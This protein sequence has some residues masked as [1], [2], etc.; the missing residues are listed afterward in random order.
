MEK[1]TNAK[2]LEYVLTNVEGLPTDVKDKLT[3]IHASYVN[4]GKA[5]KPTANQIANA[6]IA[7]T[8]LDGLEV[9]KGYTITDIQKNIEG[10]GDFTNQKISAIVRELVNG[11][12]VARTVE[13]GKAYFSVVTE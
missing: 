5:K 7:Q 6:A 10:L 9:G 13:K 4:K 2:A 11:G 12:L 8:I 3:N 1:M